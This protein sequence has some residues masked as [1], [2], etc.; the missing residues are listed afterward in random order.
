V[1]KLAQL[2]SACIFGLSDK[3]ELATLPSKEVGL[4][5]IFE[6]TMKIY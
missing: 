4:P 5:P 1:G 2:N 3:P 6:K